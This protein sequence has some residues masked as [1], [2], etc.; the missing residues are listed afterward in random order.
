MTTVINVK[1]NKITKV[2]TGPMI[3]FGLADGEPVGKEWC[4][5]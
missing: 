1:A 2:I 5:K 3:E 4:S